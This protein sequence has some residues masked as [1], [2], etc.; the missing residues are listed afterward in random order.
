[1]GGRLSGDSG[2]IIGQVEQPMNESLIT[3]LRIVMLGRATYKSGG[4]DLDAGG[5]SS[6]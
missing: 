4:P 6:D 3:L 5:D 2:G 1:M